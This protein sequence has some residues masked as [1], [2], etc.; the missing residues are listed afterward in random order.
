MGKLSVYINRGLLLLVLDNDNEG[1]VSGTKNKAPGYCFEINN[2]LGLYFALN[3]DLLVS[4][5]KAQMSKQ[6]LRLLFDVWLL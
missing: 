5:I 6:Q 3:R 2:D 4:K 1:L